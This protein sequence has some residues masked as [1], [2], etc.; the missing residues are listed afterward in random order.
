MNAQGSIFNQGNPS[1][2]TGYGRIGGG[3]GT[4]A[5]QRGVPLGQAD[6]IARN[7]GAQFDA[8]A[9]QV[10]NLASQATQSGGLG[11]DNALIKQIQDRSVAIKVGEQLETALFELNKFRRDQALRRIQIAT[12]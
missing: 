2:S 7:Y 8:M 10:G 1:V 6:G 9:R 3:Y 5:G 12:S 11:V 4:G